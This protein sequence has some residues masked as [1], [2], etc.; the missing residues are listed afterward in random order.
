MKKDE[1]PKVV[2][3][4]QTRATI[5]KTPTK[6]CDSFTVVWDEGAVRKRKAFADLN[7]A[8]LH[9]NA[10]VKNLSRGEAEILRLSGKSS[11]LILAPK[12]PLLSSAWPSILRRSSIETATF[13]QGMAA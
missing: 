3:I 12:K 6:G 1:F 7:A 8:D 10:M 9:A 2:R 5:Y 13:I 4:G 11:C